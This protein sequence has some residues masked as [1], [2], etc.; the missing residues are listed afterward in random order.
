LQVNE[1]LPKKGRSPWRWLI[2]LAILVVVAVLAYTQR[3]ELG[4]LTATVKSADPLW[5]TAAIVSQVAV[6]LMFALVLWQA[7]RIVGHR[8]RLGTILPVSFTG[9]VFNRIF[10]SSGTVLEAVGLVSRGVP[11]GAA[12]VAISLNLIS[13][14]CAFGLVL[15]GGLGYLLSNGDIHA[16]TLIALLPVLVIVT[17]IALF[18]IR[19]ARN[20]DGLTRRALRIQ[21]QAG[22]LLRRTFAPEA[23]LHFIDEMYDSLALIRTNGRGFVELVGIQSIVLLLDAAGLMLLFIALDIWPNL[24]LVLLGYAVAHTVATASSLPGGGGTFEAAMTVTF[25]QLGIEAHI[26]LAVTLLYRLLTFWLPLLVVAV[27]AN[28]IRT[29]PSETP[30]S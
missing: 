14:S 3:D 21:R 11:R 25:T 24:V 30:A 5:L 8:Q 29:A 12:T 18:V 26:A 13:G 15:L 1:V 28:R 23:V 2:S 27:T 16:R 17:I 19:Q 4:S 22:R 10:P 9:I 20:R 7:L 6:Y